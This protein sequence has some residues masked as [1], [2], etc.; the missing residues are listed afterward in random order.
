VRLLRFC[1][2][3]RES[4]TD[5]L[6]IPSS[7]HPKW[8]RLILCLE[9]CD[10]LAIA[11]SGGVDSTFLVWVAQH[12]LGKE[13]LAMLAVSPLLSAREAADA[14]R[15]AEQLQFRLDV[16][17]VDVCR[18]KTVRS[19]SPTRCYVCKKTLF[20]KMGERARALGRLRLADGTNADDLHQHRPGLEALRELDVLS[21][22][23]MAGFTKAEIRELSRLAELPNWNKPSQS[24]LA[25]RIPFG[26]VLSSELLSRIEQAEDYLWNLGCV[27]VRVRIHH[28]L[29][30][31]EVSAEDFPR[32]LEPGR[33]VRTLEHFRNLGFRRVTL[34]LAGYCSGSMDECKHLEG[35][36][37]RVR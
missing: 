23:A 34:D 10:Q 16:I 21:P 25:T 33:R 7:L 27:Q 13:A 14:R 9:S 1:V 2:L 32:L 36:R 12:H 35:E 30:R 19:N 37:A 22:L 5:A 20:A 29:A 8:L 31:I 24:C 3:A 17:E 26:V 28:D 4:M 6:S 18:H 15:V 11:Y